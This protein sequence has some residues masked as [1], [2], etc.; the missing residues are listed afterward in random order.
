MLNGYIEARS[1]GRPQGDP[2]DGHVVEDLLDA[3]PIRV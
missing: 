3:A 1:K 2:I